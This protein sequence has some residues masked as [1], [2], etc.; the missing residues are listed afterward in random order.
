MRIRVAIN[1]NYGCF[2]IPKQFQDEVNNNDKNFRLTVA[3]CIDKMENTHDKLTNE[4]YK[5]LRNNYNNWYIKINDHFYFRDLDDKY[6]N[7]H[8]LKIVDVDTDSNGIYSRS[9][10]NWYFYDEKIV[11]EINEK[12]TPKLWIVS[13]I[14]EYKEDY[15]FYIA[16]NEEH[17]LKVW[18]SENRDNLNFEEFTDEYDINELSKCGDFDIAVS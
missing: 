5:G 7:L 13:G 4:L 11:D 14:G 17:L 15:G 3:E 10:G 6:N 16:C 12:W 9:K 2:H 1:P 18:N 8:H